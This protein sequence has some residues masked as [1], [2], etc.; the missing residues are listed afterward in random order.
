MAQ[1][2][3]SDFVI[4]DEQFQN[5]YTETLAQRVEFYNNASRGTIVLTSKS[6]LGNFEK[7]SFFKSLASATLVN[8][9]DPSSVAAITAQKIEQ[10]EKIGVKLNRYSYIQNTLDSFKKIG[11]GEATFSQEVG[12]L[13]ALAATEDQFNTAIATLVGGLQV[14]GGHAVQGDGTANIDFKGVNALRFAYGDNYDAIKVLIMHSATAKAFVDLNID[15]KL[16][17]VAGVTIKTA[18]IASLGIPILITDSPSLAKAVTGLVGAN[19]ILALTENAAIIVD[20]ESPTADIQRV[21]GQQNLMLSLQ[22]EWA[23]NVSLFGIS[24][25]DTTVS[26]TNTD[27]ATPANWTKTA[28][29]VKH[30]AGVMFDSL[31]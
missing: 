25:T 26:P 19:A 7:M 18:E 29:D 5:A 21:Q 13:T 30:I 11:T 10:A 1:G 27:L 31:V 17:T 2:T 8:H 6:I 12:V 16:D 4:Y 9:R 20:S 14:T 15:E 28:T 23:F 3:L 24:Y 22:R